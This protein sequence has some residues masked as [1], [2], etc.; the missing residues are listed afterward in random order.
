[1]PARYTLEP[2]SGAI[3]VCPTELFDQV[4]HFVFKDSLHGLQAVRTHD[5]TRSDRSVGL[6]KTAEEKTA[7]NA[8][9]K[10]DFAVLPPA[11]RR[12]A[13]GT[14]HPSGKM[15][16]QRSAVQS[17]AEQSGKTVLVIDPKEKGQISGVNGLEVS[18]AN[19]WRVRED[20]LMNFKTALLDE[21]SRW[22]RSRYEVC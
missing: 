12:L 13:A 3:A 19:V 6:A 21:L 8:D 10:T 14:R 2:G 22:F 1:M 4:D 9:L 7:R 5:P 18:L 20:G 11:T 15:E 16:V 17:P